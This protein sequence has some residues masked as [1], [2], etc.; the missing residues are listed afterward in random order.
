MLY[1]L[2]SKFLLNVLKT[3]FQIKVFMLYEETGNLKFIFN[4]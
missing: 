1:F 2:T 3:K 4:N